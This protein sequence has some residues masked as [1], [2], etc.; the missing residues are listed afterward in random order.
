MGADSF[1]GAEALPSS[2]WS[3]GK[4]SLETQDVKTCPAAAPVSNTWLL[5]VSGFP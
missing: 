3:V 1:D 2:E 5:I 4:I